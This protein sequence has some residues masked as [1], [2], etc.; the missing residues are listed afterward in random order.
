V[1]DAL[2]DPIPD[3][4]IEQAGKSPSGNPTFGNIP[5]APYA[6]SYQTLSPADYV[7]FFTDPGTTQLV[8]QTAPIMLASNQNRTVVLVDDCET[9]C[10]GYASLIVADLN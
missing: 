4:Y 1:I 8:Y 3:I 10:S 9:V 7:V 5:Y 6:T 2:V